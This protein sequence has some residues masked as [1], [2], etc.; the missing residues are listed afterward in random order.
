MRLQVRTNANAVVAT[1]DIPDPV[2]T[3]AQQVFG[4]AT[5]A[6]TAALFLEWVW[7]R[8][9]DHIK[10]EVVNAAAVAAEP[11]VA[12]AKTGAGTTFDTDVPA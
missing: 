6:E 4:G 9:R 3:Y 2:L 7:R 5:N 11:Q 8:A 12:A 10:N 1:R